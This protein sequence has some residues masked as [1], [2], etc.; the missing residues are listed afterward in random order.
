MKSRISAMMDG[1]L[2]DAELAESMRAMREDGD[3][4]EAWRQYHLISDA[5]R[6]TEILSSGFSARF[7]ARLEQEPA[8]LAPSA[9]PRR[10]EHAQHRFPL[11]LAAS[12]A[13]VAMVGLIY[14]LMPGDAQLAQ[15]PAP[16]AAVQAENT[17][18]AMPKEADDYLRAHQNYS[19][20]NSL[21]GV[22]PYVRTVSD[23]NRSR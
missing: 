16:A 3:A 18:V 11:G 7:S 15:A 10:A 22:A 20:R 19:P 1:E 12:V 23:T 13:G 21:Q 14:S 2:T 9:A 17:V 4:I 6:D 5:L 8:I